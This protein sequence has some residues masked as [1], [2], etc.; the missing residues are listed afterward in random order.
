MRRSFI[1]CLIGLSASVH[2]AVPLN[3]AVVFG[4]DS[5]S[6]Q[7]AVVGL[8]GYNVPL[9][10][11][12]TAASTSA[13]TLPLFAGST[14]N[15][16]MIILGSGVIGFSADQWSQLYSYQEETNA[17][18]VSLYD[19]PDLGSNIG[20]TSL[21]SLDTTGVV[22][23]SFI[24]STVAGLPASYSVSLDGMGTTYPATVLN[25]SAVIPVLSFS[26]STG[27]TSVAAAIYTFTKNREHLS[28]FYQIA[29][30]QATSAGSI[31]KYTN[32]IL[33]SWVSKGTFGYAP[34]VPIPPVTTHAVQVQ[35]KGLI[36][37][38]G[39][40]VNKPEEYPQT[41]FQSYGL[42]FDTVLVSPAT[43]LNTPL[44]LEVTPNALGKYSVIVVTNGQMIAQFPNGSY[45]STLY[46]WQWKQIYAYQQYYGVRL[47]TID[48]TPTAATYA[49]HVSAF[50]GAAGCSATALNVVPASS[51]FTDPA[52]LKST[53]SLAAGDGL[54]GG[55]CNFPAAVVNT[56]SVTPVLNFVGSG[57][58]AAVI[59]FGRNQQQMAF[60]LPC[61]SW[62]ATCTTIGNIWFQWGTRGAYTGLRRIYFTPQID[63]VFL[64]TD[65]NDENGNPV[66]FRISPADIQGLVDWMPDINSRLPAGSNITIEMAYNGNGVMET[67]S[68]LTLD[69]KYFVD[70]DPDMTDTGLDWQKPLGTGQ[71]LWT[72]ALLAA[73]NTEWT[74][75][76]LANDPIYNYF[77]APGNLTSVSSK[78]LWC[79]HTFTHEILNN[80]TYSDTFNEVSFNFHLAS[81]DLWGLD[82][83]PFWSNKSMVTPGIS[84]LFN[85]DALKALLD[86]GI[87]GAVG[88]SSRL[89]TL[90]TVRPFWW[91][92]TTT[93]E[94]N[95]YAGF[96]VIPRQ[97][98]N[99]YFNTTNQAYNTILYNKIYNTTKTFADIMANEVSRNMRTLPL[100]SWQPVMFHQA[101][102]RN[103]DLPA[104]TIGS[105]T[106]KLSLM[107]QWVESIFGSFAE[108]ANWPILTLSQDVLTQKFINRQIYETAGV[109]VTQTL[110]ITA[111]GI[112]TSGF[113]VSAAKSCIAPVTLP[114]SVSVQD[115][116]SLP[117]GATT[118]QIGSVDSVTVWIP[119]IGGAAPVSLSFAAK[120]I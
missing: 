88:D 3:Q 94:N 68:N 37:S 110:N 38:V 99:I 67:L 33:I 23:A 42:D 21:S 98:V 116:T 108:I 84:G 14:A 22:P 50:G 117:A 5:P 63:D 113:T 86:F 43:Q 59:D 100:L 51:T 4:S 115:I 73:L 20:Y 102:L 101:N 119:L 105:K 97:S 82:G 72:P 79:S 54:V 26:S 49:G 112:V 46:D 93:V 41:V 32:E 96:T 30:W 61:G 85:G 19:S 76:I 107:Q 77:S 40:T 36:L 78:F 64:N 106:G 87:T 6:G 24:G 120:T 89:K 2:S 44:S 65:G 104:V 31:T 81:K 74:K 35:T 29:G 28:F 27:S 66:G 52:G 9:I 69:P 95:G 48:D 56:T 7:A 62:S 103:A 53:W 17:R 12:D 118:E 60:F 111:S 92:M 34:P 83:Q 47:L 58:A 114:P 109:L 75:T 15:F 45:Y 11:Y 18:L 70:I 16:S 55:S 80:N 71:T 39:D 13:S 90:N 10:A 57:A 1:L 8:T 25:T 91:P